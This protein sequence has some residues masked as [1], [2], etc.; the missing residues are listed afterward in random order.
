MEAQSQFVI[1]ESLACSLIEESAGLAHKITSRLSILMENRD[2]LRAKLEASQLIKQIDD[3]P[4]TAELDVFAVDG[5]CGVEADLSSVM[6]SAIA[7][8][9]APQQTDIISSTC[10]NCIPHLT[11][12]NQLAQGLMFMQEVILA[13]ETAKKYPEGITLIDGNRIGTLINLNQ[14][15]YALQQEEV[16]EVYEAWKT[17]GSTD[18]IA[19]LFEK[20]ETQNHLVEFL[21]SRHNIV[22]ISKLVST[23]DILRLIGEP[24]QMAVVDDRSLATLLLKEGEYTVPLYLEKQKAIHMRDVYPYSQQ[25]LAI[26]SNWHE[27]TLAWS[28]AYVYFKPT[29]KHPALKIEVTSHCIQQNQLT[30]ILQQ[31]RKEIWS[32]D[33]QEPYSMWLADRICKECVQLSVAATKEITSNKCGNSDEMR[34]ILRSHRT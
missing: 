15:Y 2:R 28:P 23:K 21:C 20:F 25:V 3:T 8:R 18:S 10:I 12:A 31:V 22:G 9:I 34:N 6:L 11:V 19:Q 30:N 24:S 1:P 17:R 27:S 33:I 5:G 4:Q 13:N 29:A 7:I 32:Q 26:S 16:T 14:F